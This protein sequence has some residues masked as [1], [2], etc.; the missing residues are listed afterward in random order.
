MGDFELVLIFFVVALFYS[1]VGFGGGS[2]YLAIMALYGIP[3]LEMKTIALVCNI[4]VVTSGTYLFYAKGLLNFKKLLPLVILSIPMAFIGGL[5]RTGDKIFLVVLG[6]SL[7]LAATLMIVEVVKK[8]KEEVISKS[9]SLV[10]NAGLGG[11]VGML[12]GFVGIGGGIF[13]APLLHFTRWGFTRQI[14]AAS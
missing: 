8:K 11:G 9:D 12:S 1:A 3:M 10:L 2:S 14:A 7:V 13:L 5:L 4:I 6:F